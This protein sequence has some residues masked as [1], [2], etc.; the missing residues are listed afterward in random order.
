MM[1]N[2]SYTKRLHNHLQHVEGV[3]FTSVLDCN[4]TLH[5]AHLDGLKLA[6]SYY[7]GELV[8]TVANKFKIE[9]KI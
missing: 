7:L 1:I 8:H 2:K 6:E 4:K 3:R 9:L 5:T